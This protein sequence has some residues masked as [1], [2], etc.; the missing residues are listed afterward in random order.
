MLIPQFACF[1]PSLNLVDVLNLPDVD[2]FVLTV[3]SNHLHFLVLVGQNLNIEWV[4]MVRDCCCYL[5]LGFPQTAEE[6][7]TKNCS[8]I[9]I[10]KTKNFLF[11]LFLS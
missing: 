3:L 10:S 4:H 9:S 1:L 2:H 8:R 5:Y 7:I 6:K 11:S